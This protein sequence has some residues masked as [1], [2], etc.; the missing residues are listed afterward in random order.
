L[1]LNLEI[2]NDFLGYIGVGSSILPTLIF[3]IKREINTSFYLKLYCFEILLINITNLVLFKFS[4]IDQNN[5]FSA[6][7]LIELILIVLIYKEYSKMRFVR[8]YNL[9]F[10]LIICVFV[11]SLFYSPE[12]RFSMFG[13]FC[14]LLLS[15]LSIFLIIIQY[16]KSQKDSLLNDSVFIFSSGVLI[17]NGIQIYITIFDN[18][19][20][21]QGN[22]LFFMI[23]PIIQIGTIIYYSLIS[24]AIWILKN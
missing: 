6:H 3:L 19:I 9:L 13:L 23:W 21:E 18:I 15:F 16:F 17:Y 24:R 7:L 12:I 2:I 20:R 11:L 22:D 1:N 4:N 14:K 8:V 5:L 10:W